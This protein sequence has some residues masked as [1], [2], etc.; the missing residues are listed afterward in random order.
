MAVGDI[1][2][3]R[4]TLRLFRQEVIIGLLIALSIGLVIGSVI[5]VF[6]GIQTGEINLLFPVAVTAGIGIGILLASAFG[7]AI[8]ILCGKM[9]LD[10][11]LVAG[12]FITSF[13]DV[14]AAITFMLVTEFILNNA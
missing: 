13:N 5:L 2:I 8:P 6:D 10:P 7:T 12:P 11:A 9:G 14:T 1:E 3:G 4:S